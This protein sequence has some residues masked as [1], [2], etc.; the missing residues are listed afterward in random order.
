MIKSIPN[1]YIIILLYVYAIYLVWEIILPRF[2]IYIFLYCELWRTVSIIHIHNTILSV[3]SV[4]GMK[5]SGI[6]K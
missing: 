3:F 2:F 1:I 6:V 4:C 5:V